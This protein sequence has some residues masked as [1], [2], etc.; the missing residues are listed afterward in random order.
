MSTTDNLITIAL[1]MMLHPGGFVPEYPFHGDLAPLDLY[2]SNGPGI[3]VDLGNG[4]DILKEVRKSCFSSFDFVLRCADG[5][6]G[7][8]RYLF[9]KTNRLP[10]D[11]IQR[12][13]NICY[14]LAI[15]LLDGLQLL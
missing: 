15:G 11:W 4:F 3:A 10:Q 2:F 9:A 14:G 7:A 5:K 1:W 12:N 8:L 13:Q 6:Q